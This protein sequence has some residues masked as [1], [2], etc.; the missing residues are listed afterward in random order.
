MVNLSEPTDNSEQERVETKMSL[1][2]DQ[3]LT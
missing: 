2:C 1:V 3:G